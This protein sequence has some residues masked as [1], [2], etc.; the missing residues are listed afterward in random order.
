MPESTAAANDP[1]FRAYRELV[2]TWNRTIPLVSRKSGEESFDRLVRESI[3]AAA[4]LPSDLATIVDIGS[5]AGLPGIPFALLR[6]AADVVLIDRSLRKTLFLKEVKRSLSLE[7]VEVRC[8]EFE[9]ARLDSRRPLAVTSLAVGEHARFLRL[10]WPRLQPGDGLLLFI[11]QEVAESLGSDVSCETLRYTQLSGR[12]H[13][14]A[15][16]LGR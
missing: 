3:E 12:A 16:W 11:Q 9:P 4:L 6:P 10:V 1:R 8:E 5:G 7:R 14:G 15:A 13:T 2:M